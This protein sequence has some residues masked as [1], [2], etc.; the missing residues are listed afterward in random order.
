MANSDRSTESALS[1]WRQ[2]TRL[3]IKKALCWRSDTEQGCCC[4]V[5]CACRLCRLRMDKSEPSVVEA[6]VGER[7]RLPCTVEASPALAI[8]WQKDGQPLS[9]PRWAPIWL[10]YSCGRLWG[11]E[12]HSEGALLLA[13]ADKACSALCWAVSFVRARQWC[14]TALASVTG[15]SLDFKL[16]C[17]QL[18]YRV[19][20]Q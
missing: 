6:K 18:W 7:V 19:Y 4:T 20:R 17:E 12:P 16:S 3:V 8:E 15:Q 14:P 10:Y 5:C 2:K 9:P 13:S 1:H 11:G